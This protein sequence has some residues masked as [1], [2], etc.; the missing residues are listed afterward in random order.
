MT[1]EFEIG[2]PVAVSHISIEEAL[3]DLKEE[4]CGFTYLFTN[5]LGIHCVRLVLDDGSDYASCFQYITAIPEGE[6]KMSEEFEIGEFEIGQQVAVSNI[7]I[8]RALEQSEKE[9]VKY[10]YLHAMSDGSVIVRAVSQDGSDYASCF[11]Y[12]TALPEEP[13]LLMFTHKTFPRGLVYV[14]EK[15]SSA[16]VVSEN[17][18]LGIRQHT[19]ATSAG[20]PTYARLAESLE[21]SLD[22][23][24]TWVPCGE[25]K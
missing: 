21:M 9:S 12:V 25:L 10:Y 22:N 3:R 7:S 23:G 20:S 24:K 6:N 19:I 2:Q 4:S 5:D 16:I 18:V 8:E 15:D 11:N 17:L 1:E 14:R 13:K